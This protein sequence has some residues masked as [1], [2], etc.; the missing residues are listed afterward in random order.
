[1]LSISVIQGNVKIAFG[2]L[3]ADSGD[4]SFID[5]V[6]VLGHALQAR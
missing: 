3:D 2:Q 5:N 1:M 6:K 4:Y